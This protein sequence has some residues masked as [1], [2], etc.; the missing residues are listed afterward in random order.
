[1]SNFRI[2][3]TRFVPLYSTIMPYFIIIETPF[4]SALI[5][6]IDGVR[7]RPQTPRGT[8]FVSLHENIPREVNKVF[9][10]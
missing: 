10:S 8:K 9:A 1:M 6:I 7:F 2:E 4:V 5:Y 3:P